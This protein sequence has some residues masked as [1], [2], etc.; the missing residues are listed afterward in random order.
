MS[1]TATRPPKAF[2]NPVASSTGLP[3]GGRGR[4]GKAGASAGTAPADPG[5]ARP[6]QQG[7]EPVRRGLQDQH[8]QGA[9]DDGFVVAAMAQQAGEQVLQLVVHQRDQPGPEQRAPD[10][11]GAAHHR[12]QQVLDAGVEAERG[13]VHAALH[14]GVQPPRQPGEHRG[15]GEGQHPRPRQ[16]HPEAGRRGGTRR[17]APGSPGRTRL[18]IRLRVSSSDGRHA[19]PHHGE[20]TPGCPVSADAADPTSVRDAGDAVVAPDQVQVAEHVIQ[21]DGPRDGSQRQVV[22]GQP[23]RHQLRSAA[24]RQA[25]WPAIGHRQRQPTATIPACVVSSAVA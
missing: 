4:M 1:W 13:G 18:S 11:S 15:I 17:A 6:A 3:A 22:P 12:H 25:G 8:Q 7:P 20:S 16:V 21:A 24:P 10:R 19:G 5:A 9:E 2:R 14:V 23:Q